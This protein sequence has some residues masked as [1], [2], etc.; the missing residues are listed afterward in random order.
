MTLQELEA[1]G[2]IYFDKIQNGMDEYAWE[3]KYDVV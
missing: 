2:G 3:S 1:E